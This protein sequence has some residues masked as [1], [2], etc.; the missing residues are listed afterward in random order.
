ME[1]IWFDYIQINKE[2]IIKYPHIILPF[3][4]INL[5]YNKAQLKV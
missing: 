4:F 5:L 3:I 2:I 1:V